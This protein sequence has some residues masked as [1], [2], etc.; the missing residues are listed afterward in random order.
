MTANVQ[1]IL[2]RAA[3]RCSYDPE[4]TDFFSG[5]D[6]GGA[7][8]RTYLHDTVA[9]IAQ[10]TDAAPLAASL[11]L[12]MN[13]AGEITG[14]ATFS[15]GLRLPVTCTT[16]ARGFTLPEYVLRLSRE[17]RAFFE[18]TFRRP[19][20]V[21][22]NGGDWALRVAA[23][24]FGE[25]RFYCPQGLPGAIRLACLP[26]PAPFLPFTLTVATDRWVRAAG[27]GGLAAEANSGDDVP[28]I[29]ERIL[30]LGIVREFR[31]RRGLDWESVAEQF[32]AALSRWD[33]DTK[34]RQAVGVGA[35]RPLSRDVYSEVDGRPLT[36]DLPD[37]IAPA[38]GVR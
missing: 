12:A 33:N 14:A 11:R 24:A 22:Q 19:R 6:Q 13:Y 9:E 27:E 32:E 20:V 1:T 26:M 35:P 2:S 28:L 17:P 36:P 25:D 4:G 16:D 31:R 10:R 29:P 37:Y 5:N 18:D 8:L 38:P 3:R 15:T 23:G 21:V 34:T 7:E 30:E